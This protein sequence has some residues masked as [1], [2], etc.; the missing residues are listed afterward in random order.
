MKAVS[1]PKTLSNGYSV[2]KYYVSP[3]LLYFIVLDSYRWKHCR[4]RLLSFTE[5]EKSGNWERTSNYQGGLNTDRTFETWLWRRHWPVRMVNVI[6]TWVA[7][8]TRT[9]EFRLTLITCRRRRHMD[10]I[11]LHQ[12]CL[13]SSSVFTS[14]HFYAAL[15]GLSQAKILKNRWFYFGFLIWP[16]Y[17]VNMSID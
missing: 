2:K 8:V 16:Y 13:M 4:S 9:S 11:P 14:G 1:S 3:P 6:Q 5:E 17:D 7:H 12:D 10:F 15:K